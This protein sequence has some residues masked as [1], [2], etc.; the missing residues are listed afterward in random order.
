[1]KEEG[2][3][4]YCKFPSSIEISFKWRKTNNISNVSHEWAWMKTKHF[5]LFLHFQMTA[6]PKS[7][8]LMVTLQIMFIDC[9]NSIFNVLSINN[10]S[11]FLLACRQCFSDTLFLTS[12]IG[13]NF[14]PL[15]CFKSKIA[16][17][18]QQCGC[19]PS[20]V[21]NRHSVVWPLLWSRLQPSLLSLFSNTKFKCRHVPNALRRGSCCPLWGRRRELGYISCLK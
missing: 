20:Q 9:L 5:V 21:S 14:L 1:M 6:S 19:S 18:S 11:G 2:F 12:P 17:S 4:H 7:G 10:S 15:S 8:H 3:W 16:L 13:C